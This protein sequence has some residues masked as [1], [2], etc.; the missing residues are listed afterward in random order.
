MKL[1][2]KVP[3]KLNLKVVIILSFIVVG[4]VSMLIVRAASYSI[5]VEPEDGAITGCAQVT[6]DDAASGGEAVKFGCQSTCPPGQTGTHPNCIPSTSGKNCT[7]NLGNLSNTKNGPSKLIETISGDRICIDSVT[8]MTLY[9]KGP[10]E[11]FWIGNFYYDA[12]Q[13]TG[14]ANR[15]GGWH[16]CILSQGIPTKIVAEPKQ[17]ADRA[18]Y[19]VGG[20]DGSGQNLS[21]RLLEI[22][23]AEIYN[24]G[25]DALQINDANFTANRFIAKNI[26]GNRMFMFDP[27]FKTSNTTGS[28]SNNENVPHVDGIQ[29]IDNGTIRL[30]NFLIDTGM[31]SAI[32]ASTGTRHSNG[33]IKLYLTNG[34]ITNMGIKYV[35]QERKNEMK[36]LSDSLGLVYDSERGANSIS[37]SGSTEVHMDKITVTSTGGNNIRFNNI[38]A[39]SMKNSTIIG[40]IWLETG[41]KEPTTWSNN[42]I[43]SPRSDRYPQKAC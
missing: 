8:N 38:K 29:V 33:T 30:N 6:S 5:V 39:W 15:A 25:E 24:S 11:Y 23:N 22:D 9:I 13:T 3:N 10:F 20:T 34:T 40:G 19:V 12:T 14:G 4:T 28:Y 7:Q 17:C 16:N 41:C 18:L 2:L 31:M 37:A 42:V 32:I 36:Q 1:R 21:G 27:N 26:W 35:S 43:N